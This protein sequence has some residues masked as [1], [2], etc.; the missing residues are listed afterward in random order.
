MHFK[1]HNEGW[2]YFVS[3][4]ILTIITF[5][6]FPIIGILL[7]LLSLCLFYFFRDPLRSVPKEDVIVSPADGQIVF[8]GESD[9]N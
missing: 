4:V 2:V 1:I 6:F 8:I 9:L 5:P 3:A 7:A